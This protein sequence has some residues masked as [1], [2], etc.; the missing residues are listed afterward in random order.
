MLRTPLQK[1]FKPGL[2]DFTHPQFWG[3]VR[4]GLPPRTRPSRDCGTRLSGAL[5]PPLLLRRRA[6]RLCAKVRGAAR[7]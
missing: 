1:G 5:L 2:I 4:R 7:D 6:D 3:L